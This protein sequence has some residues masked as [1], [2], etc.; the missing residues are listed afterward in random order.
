[1]AKYDGEASSL[2]IRPRWRC[3]FRSAMRT[4]PETHFPT[5]CFLRDINA[6]TV[7]FV[8]AGSAVPR[9][10]HGVRPLALGNSS[11]TP[12]ASPTT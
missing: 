11:P 3:G 2:R 8:L 9:L 5:A 1:V 10:R 12:P 4:V 6:G 7:P